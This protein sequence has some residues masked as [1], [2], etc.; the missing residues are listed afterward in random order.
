MHSAYPNVDRKDL[1]LAVNFWE[2]ELFLPKHGCLWPLKIP[3][4]VRQA[5]LINKTVA[6]KSGWCT[7]ERTNFSRQMSLGPRARSFCRWKGWSCCRVQRLTQNDDQFRFEK[8]RVCLW[9]GCPQ[10]VSKHPY[11]I[12]VWE[13]IVLPLCCACSANAPFT[14]RRWSTEA[15]MR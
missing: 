15:D 11:Q 14:R 8:P 4:L 12:A 2:R 9:V 5:S 3:S 10:N 1:L 6:G 7:N 13:A